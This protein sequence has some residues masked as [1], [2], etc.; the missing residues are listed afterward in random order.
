MLKQTIGMT[1]GIPGAVW[2]DPGRPLLVPPSYSPVE[3]ARSSV[4]LAPLELP[5]GARALNMLAVV[6]A[7][8]RP[9]TFANSR[10][11]VS[12]PRLAAAGPFEGA[13]WPQLQA[14]LDKLPV[15]T[16]ANQEGQPLQYEVGEK[17][18]AVFYADVDA[19]K[20]ELAQSIAQF[21][22]LGCDLIP[23]GLGSAYKLTCEGK[24]MLVPGI[25]D[26][27][28]AGAPEGAEPMGQELPLFAC[29][30]MSQAGENGPVLPLFVSHADCA[31]AVEQATATE[32]PEQPLEI[33]CLSL[34]GVVERLASVAMPST[35][36]FTF[37]APDKTLE[38]IASYLGQGVYW[39]EVDEEK[40]P[41]ILED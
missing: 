27:M 35:G 32:S 37:M 15:F 5:V 31:A 39:K 6:L 28:A 10:R 22:D 33:S 18:M 13:G 16:V 1:R 25:A 9:H 12:S 34:P 20:K 24:A 40:A 11:V 23:V 4:Q 26:L 2:L 14:N 29:M 36:G 30:D 38:H 8:A 7:S 19:A 41:V 21:P 3:R 17:P